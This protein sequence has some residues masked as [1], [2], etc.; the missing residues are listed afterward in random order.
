MKDQRQFV[1]QRD[2]EVALGVF[3]DLGG[4]GHLDAAW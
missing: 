1:H 4:F 3:D 2:I